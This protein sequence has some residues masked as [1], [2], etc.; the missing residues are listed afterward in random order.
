MSSNITNGSFAIAQ[1]E[2]LSVPILPA[3]PGSGFVSLSPAFAGGGF[4]SSGVNPT[5]VF[6]SAPNCHAAPVQ[7]QHNLPF[8]PHTVSPNINDY[9]T[10]DANLWRLAATTPIVTPAQC[11]NAGNI[12]SNVT[13]VGPSC[14]TAA[15]YTSG[16]TVC[17]NTPPV[18]PQ[19]V[20]HFVNHTNTGYQPVNE[21]Y[22]PSSTYPNQGCSSDRPLSAR[23]LAELLMHSRKDH[24]PECK[25][26]QFDDNPLNLHEWFG[27]FKSTVDS[28][29]LTDDTKL[30]YLKTLVT[31]KAK[32]A[33][34]EVSNSGVM[35]KDAL[36]TLQRKF[37]QPH[38]IVGA[39][40]DKLN[41]FPPLKMHNSEN[42]ISFSA[43]I[44]GL[45]VVFK[46]LSFNDDLK[47]VNLLN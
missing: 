43:A 16:G 17:F 18:H 7:T 15:P 25:I 2:S 4:S 11:C 38:A 31:G 5:P 36:A 23:E 46:S 9:Y 19:H 42:I 1:P 28:A 33:I 44:S 45:V 37:G 40:L 20:S 3:K 13:T 34:A 29:V 12:F 26:A 30:K 24:L 8:V 32:T 14:N 35:Y 27:Q 41:T 22:S 39:H 47:S 21:D 6:F 10:S